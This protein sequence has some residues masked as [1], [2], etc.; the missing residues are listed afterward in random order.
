MLIEEDLVCGKKKIDFLAQY[1][2]FD[3]ITRAII[4]QLSIP[5]GSYHDEIFFI[6]VPREGI[7]GVS[8]V[9]RNKA[10][11]KTKNPN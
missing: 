9:T 10:Q 6:N 2:K 11:W 1:S 4:N 3:Q 8:C 5:N 7:H